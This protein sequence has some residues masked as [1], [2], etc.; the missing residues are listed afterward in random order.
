MTGPND[1]GAM[2]G[3]LDF[4]DD[5]LNLDFGDLTAEP[6][7]L[8]AED[9]QDGTEVPATVTDLSGSKAPSVPAGAPPAQEQTPPAQAVAPATAPASAPATPPAPGA[10]PPAQQ[11]QQPPVE[12]P[13]ATEQPQPTVNIEEF[14]AANQ[15]AI[16]GNLASSHFAIDDKTAEALGFTPEVRD[17]VQKRDARNFVLT[18]VQ[19]NNALQRTL[20]TVVGQLVEIA[21]QTKTAKTGFFEEFNDLNDPKYFQ[22]LNQLAPVLRAANPQMDKKAFQTLLGNTARLSLG[23]PTP[24]A[25]PAQQI[26]GRNVRR[27]QPRAF[28][29][30][31]ALTPQ[32]NQAG[33]G[34]APV[35][36]LAFMNEQLRFGADD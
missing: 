3:D 34:V 27:G 9:M 8:N 7:D 26:S 23:L 21:Q 11:G 17:F 35:D 13:G 18:M 4:G 6:G 36:P 15:D 24:Q 25:Q 16:I 10:Q 32:R 5:F 29:P 31:G 2:D 14:V 1:D 12:Q 30:A 20:P 19:V 33:N 28:T 22:V